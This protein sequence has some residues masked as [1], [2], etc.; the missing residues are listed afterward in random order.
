MPT[1]VINKDG[2]IFFCMI[3]SCTFPDKEAHKDIIRNYIME[4]EITKSNSMESYQGDIIRHLKQYKNIKGTEWKKVL[5]TIIK[6]YRKINKLAFQTGLNPKILTSPKRHKYHKWLLDITRW[7]IEIEQDFISRN[8]WPK[9]K[10]AENE[11]LTT[12]PMNQ[13]GRG[14]NKDKSPSARIASWGNGG[15]SPR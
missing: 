11:E 14:W 3:I 15:A 9:V 5:K 13:V 1:D 10:V 8:L 7:T 2:H 6:Q 12:M 4:L